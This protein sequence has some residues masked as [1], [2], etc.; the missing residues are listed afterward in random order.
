[1]SFVRGGGSHLRAA[2]CMGRLC[3]TDTAY[4]CRHT[5]CAVPLHETDAMRSVAARAYTTYVV[6]ECVLLRTVSANPKRAMRSTNV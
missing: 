2:V 4:I 1:M 5:I 6:S 3:Q